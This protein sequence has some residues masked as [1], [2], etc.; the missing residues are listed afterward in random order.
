MYPL[1]ENT[2]TYFKKH[3]TDRLYDCNEQT[4]HPVTSRINGKPRTGSWA[5]LL[6]Q[7]SW[8][9]PNAATRA[10]QAGK[11]PNP[12]SDG[13]GDGRQTSSLPYRQPGSRVD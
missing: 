2:R 13:T 8:R 7:H 12:T 5:R 11:A 9:M 4:P 1:H 10:Y 6:R 3:L